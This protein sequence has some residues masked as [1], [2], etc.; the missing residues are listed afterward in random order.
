MSIPMGKL[1]EPF[2]PENIKQRQG[3]FGQTLDYIN[4]A[5][6][7]QRLNEVLEGEWAFTILD[8]RIDPDEVIVKGRMKVGGWVREQFGGY[9][10]VVA[11]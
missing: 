3:F 8:Y 6:V 1:S 7:I 9:M 2:P 4:A 5:T 10:T 11:Q